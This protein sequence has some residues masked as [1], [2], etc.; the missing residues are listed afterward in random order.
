VEPP[1]PPP[2]CGGPPG[3]WK[4]PPDP[5]ELLLELLD[6]PVPD[7]PVLDEPVP[8][9]PVLDEPVPEDPVPDEPVPD[10]PV[11]DELLPEDP[12]PDEPVPTADEPL[13]EDDEPVPVWVTAAWLEPGRIAATAPAAT[14]LAA[15]RVTVVAFSRR[16]PCWRSATACATWR[17][18]ARSDLPR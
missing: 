15:V 9:D 14:T 3:A 12:V 18:A 11:P 7:D 13:P 6:E 17:A 5:V 1:P 2:P 4:L 16:R 8:D 10:E